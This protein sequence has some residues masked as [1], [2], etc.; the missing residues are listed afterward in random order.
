MSA[1]VSIG[2][3]KQYPRQVIEEVLASGEPTA[4][5][6]RGKPVGVTLTPTGAPRKRWLTAADVVDIPDFGDADIL[7]PLLDELR[8]DDGDLADPWER[9][10]RR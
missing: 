1:T 9:R 5:L 6:D 4:I 8:A 3:V 2:R 7:R 10:A